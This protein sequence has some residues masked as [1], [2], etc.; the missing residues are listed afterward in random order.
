[1]ILTENEQRLIKNSVQDLLYIQYP[2][3][4]MTVEDVGEI[5]SGLIDNLYDLEKNL[6]VDRDMPD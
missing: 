2:S 4:D 5:V 3:E 6:Y 1:M